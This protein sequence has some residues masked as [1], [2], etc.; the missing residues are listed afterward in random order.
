MSDGPT[1]SIATST[2]RRRLRVGQPRWAGQELVAL[3]ERRQPSPTAVLLVASSGAFLTF[4]DT[5]VVA[6]AFPDIRRSFPSADIGSLSWIFNGYSLVFAVFLVVAGSLADVLGRRRTFAFGVALFTIASGLCAAADSVE[7]LVGF[8][9][10]QGFGAAMLV[11]ASLAL[12]I[13]GFGAARR[14][15][16]VTLWGAAA[17]IAAG[18]GPPVGGLLV[19]WGGWRLVFLVN[20]PLGIAMMMVA[21]RVLVESRAAGRRR[22]P[23]LRGATLLA[24]ALGLLALGLVKGGEWGWTSA[25]VTGSLGAGVLALVGFVVGSRSHP[26][27]LIDPALLHIRSFVAA[28]LLSAV[29][30]AGSY[31]YFLTQVLYLNYVWGYSQLKAGLAVAPAAL[32]AAIVAAVLGGVADRHGHRMIVTVGALVWAAGVGWFLLRVGPEPDFLHVWLP[33]QLLQG[34][35]LGAVSPLLGSAAVARLPEGANYATASA[36]NGAARLFGSATGVAV[37]VILIGKTEHGAS[38]EA[39]R[40]GWVMSACCFLAISISAVSLGRTRNQHAQV[41]EPAR[42]LAPRVEPSGPPPVAAPAEP[43]PDVTKDADLLGRLPLFAGLDTDTV[44]ELAHHAEEF[45]LQAGT[46]LFHAGDV[47]DS[48]YVVRRGRL[49]VL[50]QDIALRELGRGE[51]VGELGLLV[52]APRSASIRALRDS[53]LVRLTKAQFDRIAERGA[54]TAL[55]RTLAR[56]LHQAPPPAVP[57]PMSPEVVVVVIGVGA[58]APAQA[59][60]GALVIAL[61]TRLRVVDPG[62][63]DRD[64]LDRAERSADKVVL[65]ALISDEGWLDF[66]LRVADRIVLVAGDPAPPSAPLPPRAIGADLV[67][68]GPAATREHRRLW[69]ELI[70]PRSVHAA[71]HRRLPVDLGPLAARIAGRSV[72]LVLGGGGAR[73]LAHIGVLEELERAG[74]TVDRFAGT[75]M[76]AIIAAS[77]AGGLNA[78]AVDAQVYECFVRRNPVG[79]YTLPTKGLIRGRRTAALLQKAFGERL[80]EE[81]PKQ[82]RCVSVD[83]LSRRAV[84]HRRGLLADAVGCSLRVPGLYPPQVYNGQLHVDGA[85]L[86][87]IPASALVGSDGPLIAVHVGYE[88]DAPTDPDSPPNVPGIGDTLMSSMAIGG[89]KAVDSAL[90]QVQVVIRPDIRAIGF[91]EF[92]QIDAAR[93]AGRAAAREA[94]PQ[95]AALLH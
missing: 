27:P 43:V 64:G 53:T 91:L 42:M 74:I 10:L 89:Q 46:Y 33:G 56:R 40:R 16:A 49:Q 65:H 3:T 86:E 20:L 83:L 59:V 6:V 23:D 18:L 84:V 15:Q 41:I 12:V 9:V 8:R 25:G 63:V 68:A 48:L 34:I 24:M 88:P 72:G 70:A 39:L 94:L 2:P 66:C 92:H 95:I 76:G 62:R 5:T 14:A 47:S 60:A 69:E 71:D 21:S 17:A 52:D 93:E 28:N 67:L 44:A 30:V 11:P 55:I 35:G 80:V 77:A 19:A 81:L 29:A 22:L 38:A 36:V 31:S 73:G 32:V 61:S 37:L 51:V 1:P 85:V 7:A 13:E 79:D 54:L 75:S 4:L 45:E 87:S 57:P 82:F 78:A 26:V 50:Q 90:A 58:D